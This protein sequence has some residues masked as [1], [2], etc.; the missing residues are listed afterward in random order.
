MATVLITGS[1]RRLGK[2]L[3][4]KFAE[5]SWNVIV[6]YNNSEKEAKRTVNDIIAIGC[7]AVAIKA[8]VK[9][10]TEIINAINQG[11]DKL[12]IPDV[13][14]NNAGVFPK[15]KSLQDISLD[16]WDNTL[17]TNLRGEFLFAKAFSKYAKK[18]SK[19]INIASL[20]GLEIWN[21]RIPYNVSKSAV[22]QLTKALARELAPDIA[23]NCI[24][25]GAILIEDDISKTNTNLIDVNKIPMKRYG[26][27][28]DIF[29]ATYF[30]A[31]ATTYITGQ[32]LTVDGGYHFAR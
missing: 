5:K 10:E 31:T 12:G 21:K 17:N 22:I 7:K 2:G 6:H 32:V 20:G 3:A 9:S 13:L 19:I 16:F 25:P 15:K 18:G 28:Q 26:S 30:F 8:D 23:V 24:N 1:G 4:I 27:V 11:I 14:V 29:E